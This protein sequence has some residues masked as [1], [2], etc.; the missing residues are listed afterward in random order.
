MSAWPPA[1]P[2]IHGR[3][4]SDSFD[5]SALYLW[6]YGE[7]QQAILDACPRTRAALEALP[8]MAIPGRGPTAFFSLLKPGA[9]IPPHTGVSNIRSIGRLRSWM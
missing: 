1:R 5:W 2:K 6:K 9:R 7:P 3:T 4:L 8:G